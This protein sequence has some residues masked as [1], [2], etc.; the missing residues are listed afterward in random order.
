MG[1][2]AFEGISLC[3]FELWDS[4]GRNQAGGLEFGVYGGCFVID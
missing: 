1:I 4:T 2:Y 3:G